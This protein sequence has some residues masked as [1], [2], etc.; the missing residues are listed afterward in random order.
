MKEEI[1][2]IVQ[3]HITNMNKIKEEVFIENL[4]RVINIQLESL[5]KSGKILIAGNGGS[6]SDA[7]HFAGE[8]VGRFL[9]ERTAL[10][11]IALNTDTSVMT[12]IGN[13]YGFEEIF[14]RQVEALGTKGDVFIGI[15]TSGNSQNIIKA[16][17]KARQRNLTTIGLLGRDGGKLK[18]LCD[19]SIIVPF[20]STARVQEAHITL[21]H[22]MC[23]MIEKYMFKKDS[24]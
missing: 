11:A 2:N 10:P 14:A 23:E 17:E 18:D 21:I 1:N 5:K 9:L 12:C 22:I 4:E 19:I 16:V 15:S 7:Q 24:K 3:T 20:D 6:A 13:D 8:L